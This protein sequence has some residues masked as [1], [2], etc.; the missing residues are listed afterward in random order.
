MNNRQFLF[1]VRLAFCI[2]LIWNSSHAQTISYCTDLIERK[3]FIGRTYVAG[4]QENNV[5][6]W[7]YDM[8][9]NS[10]PLE[11]SICNSQMRLI[12][13]LSLKIDKLDAFYGLAF[14]QKNNCKQVLLEYNVKGKWIFQLYNY[15]EVSG[16]IAPGQL[17]DEADIFAQPTIKFSPD[18][19]YTGLVQAYKTTNDSTL[20]RYRL[21]NDG[22]H[23]MRTVT[24]IL[25]HQ[26][27]A[28]DLGESVIDN[29]G[30]LIF[31]TSNAGNAA[32]EQTMTVYKVNV[33]T[34][35][36]LSNDFFKNGTYANI[37]LQLN[38]TDE[39][40]DISG[41]FFKAP[42]IP[43]DKVTN[44]E[45]HYFITQLNKDL[46][47]QSN[48]TLLSINKIMDSL[49]PTNTRINAVNMVVNTDSGFTVTISG[50]T[51]FGVK[52]KQP[53]TG[54]PYLPPP[55]LTLYK[56]YSIGNTMQAAPN[57]PNVYLNTTPNTASSQSSGGNN[58]YPSNKA[59]W[60]TSTVTGKNFFII[61]SLN[62]NGSLSIH[63]LADK[64]QDV[65][66]PEYEYVMNTEK[67]IHFLFSR[68]LKKDKQAVSDI[69]FENNKSLQLNPVLV[70]PK[71]TLL[72]NESVQI[73][74]D[75]IL[76][77]F[78]KTNGLSFAKMEFE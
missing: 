58:N 65:S 49:Y 11:L 50:V 60:L 42:S 40:I 68:T 64:P 21:Y 39:D 26:Y 38:R 57:V 61:L 16:T 19:R 66:L 31:Y 51:D 56:N 62:K 45:A 1:S 27:N 69:I 2:L 55:D 59:G 34:D 43:L 10:H 23:P 78:L 52:L 74:P 17:I 75:A 4:Q 29:R 46:S 9:W 44:Q 15:D 22:L 30:N 3:M 77:P 63:H 47:Q 6:I 5:Y 72:V 70:N 71:F 20:I 7:H 12:K 13:K 18:G 76:I 37:K 32:S 8:W 25:P 53:N 73:S 36:L 41:I 67:N 54:Q 33:E 48:M 35:S 24:F 28:F 14:F